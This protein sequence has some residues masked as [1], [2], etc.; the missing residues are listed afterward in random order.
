MRFDKH[1]L[2]K[3]REMRKLPLLPWVFVF[4]GISIIT[5]L[6]LSAFGQ[7]SS[8]LKEGIEQYNRE[9]YEEAIEALTKARTEAPSSADAA[10]FLGM[11]YRQTNDIQNAYRQFSDAVNLKPLT[12]NAILE[13]IEVSTLLDKLDV[14][15]KWIAV[16]E[17]HKVY[18]ARVAFLKGAA[19][20]K[21]KKFDEAIAAFEKAKQLDPAYTQSADFQIGVCLMN[22]RKYAQAH[23]LF[24]SAITKDPLSDMA[25]YARRYQ[26]AAEQ[27]RYIERPLRLTIGVVGQYNS[28]YRAL[29]DPYA[30]A[31]AG[32]N[33]A[34]AETDKRSLGMQNTVRLD[35]V[36]VLPAPFVFNAGYGLHNTLHEKY[37]TDN[38]TLANS[39]T[40]APGV[41]FE[42]FAVNLV[43]NY[44]HNLKRDPSYNRY[45]ESSSVG[46]LFRYLV[47]KNRILEASAAYTR[48][49]FFK[50]VANPDLEDQTSRG[51][52]SSISWTW[53]FKENALF[54]LRLGYTKDN[55]DGLHYDNQ[56]YR[57]SLNLIYPLLDA[58]RLQLGG[59]FYLQ[60]YKNENVIFD[61]T[62]RK[63]R[64][65]TGTV[66]LTW[67]AF[68][69]VDVIAQYLYTRVN[70]NIY[71]FDYKLDVFSLGV[72]LKF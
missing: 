47:S 63:D 27:W 72:E 9:N 57:T 23:D 37:G 18:P 48:K 41:S 32:Y 12:D 7:G 61:N 59:E 66:G 26:E 53:L 65:Y 40:V 34:L 10:L 19:R 11:A 60:D 14:A 31:P 62:V 4:I 13:M 51:L 50:A 36:P 39:F 49:N 20:A 30:L 45:S 64:T 52:D 16:A 42:Q 58:L 54:N 17:G 15:N 5:M 44:T 3:G 28:N 33:D 2:R 6:P 1:Q 38:D 68:K 70:S 43:A 67:S 55:A 46:P 35:F 22:Q 56:G 8:I 69:H 29:G 24:Q 71:S 21:E 25:S